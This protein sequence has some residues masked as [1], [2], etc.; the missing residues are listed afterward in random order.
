MRNPWMSM[1]LSAANR[2]AGAAR[3][4]VMAE[5]GRQR[6]VANRKAAKQIADF[7]TGG[8]TA[9]PSKKKRKKR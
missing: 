9:R 3:S 8:L 6:S 5:T 2:V 4:R 7:W 1:Y